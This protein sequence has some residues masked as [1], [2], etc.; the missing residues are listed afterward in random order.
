M[1]QGGALV[2]CYQ[3]GTVL[4]SHGGTEMGYVQVGFLTYLISVA[5]SSFKIS[6]Q[7]RLAYQSVPSCCAGIWNSTGARVCQR[8]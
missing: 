3:D 7:T 6:S 5:K 2:H 1:N 4:V 8:F